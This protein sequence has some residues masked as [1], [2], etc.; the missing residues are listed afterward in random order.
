MTKLVQLSLDWLAAI[1]SGIAEDAARVQRLE[2]LERRAARWP[3]GKQ[4]S[5]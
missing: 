5:S 3:R 1:L 4:D 2:E